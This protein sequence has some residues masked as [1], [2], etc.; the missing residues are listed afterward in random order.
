MHVW[1]KLR[2]LGWLVVPFLVLL[3]S[4]ALGEDKPV[5]NPSVVERIGNT[6]KKVGNKIEQGLTKAATKLEQKKIG[7]KIEQKL[8]KAGRKTAEGLK[9]AGEKIDQKLR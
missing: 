4:V 6:A 1:L 9:K 5:N 8:R 7:E 2:R 3:N